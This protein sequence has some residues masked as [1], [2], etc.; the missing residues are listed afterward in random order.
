MSSVS[1]VSAF[2]TQPG[3]STASTVPGMGREFESFIRLLTA[4]IRNQDPMSPL[5]STQFVEQLATFS[6]LE[7]QVRSN[8]S[9]ESIATMIYDMGSLIA[10][11]WLGKTV[12]FESSWIPY[13]GSDIEFSADIP[14]GT[15]HSALTIRDSNGQVIWTETLAPGA[16]SYSWDGRTSSGATVPVDSVLQ[17]RIDTYKDNQQTGSIAPRVITTVTSVGSEDGA[18]RVG[19]SSKLSAD[20]ASVQIVDPH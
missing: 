1:D 9:L 3:A 2:Q 8:V 16:S 18:L 11:Q 7:Q 17:F 12:S 20:L 13:T 14:A 4:Q 15:D 6:A 5:D 10:G 19:T